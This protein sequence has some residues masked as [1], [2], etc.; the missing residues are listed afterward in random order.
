MSME[1]RSTGREWQT[2]DR[3]AALRCVTAFWGFCLTSIQTFGIGY[4]EPNGRAA[5]GNALDWFPALHVGFRR[6]FRSHPPKREPGSCHPFRYSFATYLLEDGYLSAV[7]TT[8]QAGDIRT[9]Q[10]LLGHKDVKTTMIYTHADSVYNAERIAH[11]SLTA[12]ESWANHSSRPWVLMRTL[13]Q[14]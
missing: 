12:W 1:A 8:A 11:A 5:S 10:E 7:P 14:K 6:G 3:S 9:I 13:C 4:G 2:A